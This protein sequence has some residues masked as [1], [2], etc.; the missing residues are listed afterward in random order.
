LIFKGVLIDFGGTL[1][2]LDE[3]KFGEY[4][5]ALVSTLRKYGY[6]RH[7][8]DLSAVLASIYVN[9][10]KGELKTPQEFW[11]L[12]LKKLRIRERSELIDAVQ[13]VRSNYEGTMWKLYDEVLETL[14]ILRKKYRLALV[15]NCAVGTDRLIRSLGLADFFGCIILSYQ[16]GVRKPDKRVYLEALRCLE[17][18]AKECVFVAD[19]I[20]DLEGAREIG[21]KTILVRQGLHPVNTFQDAKDRNFKPDFQISR[22][23][24]VTKIL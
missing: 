12:V 3:I 6:E 23:S 15:S 19:E 7:L 22:I 13:L 4:E 17:L 2:Y 16:V 18:E 1:V 20:S 24:E 14:T 5:A 21:L 8:K 10:S 11:S 9:S